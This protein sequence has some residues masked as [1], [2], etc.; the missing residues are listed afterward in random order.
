MYATGE[1]ERDIRR[2]RRVHG[3]LSAFP[4]KDRF[5][6]YVAANVITLKVSGEN[7]HKKTRQVIE[8]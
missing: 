2:L 3:E 5:A 4:G 1:K 6:F 7:R 8:L